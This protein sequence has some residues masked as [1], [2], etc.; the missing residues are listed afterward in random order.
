MDDLEK[1]TMYFF[2]CTIFSTESMYFRGAS[3]HLPDASVQIGLTHARVTA[4]AQNLLQLDAM[5]G[6]ST[7]LGAKSD[8][9]CYPPGNNG[10]SLKQVAS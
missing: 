6:A 5:A 4:G 10:L 7:E 9:R 8:Q 3:T 1:I 2:G